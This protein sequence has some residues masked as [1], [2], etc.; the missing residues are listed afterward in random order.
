MIL[1]AS[2]K[3]FWETDFS[4]TPLCKICHYQ[5]VLFKTGC[6]GPKSIDFKNRNVK[7]ILGLASRDIY[8]V[9]LVMQC[10]V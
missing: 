8:N 7:A 10:L 3:S 9:Q 4:F 6:L 5:S 2:F 1:S